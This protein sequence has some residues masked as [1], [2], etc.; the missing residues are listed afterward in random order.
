[1]LVWDEPLI[2]LRVLGGIDKVV[3][4]CFLDPF[5]FLLFS[6]LS[7][8]LRL[9][10]LL[11]LL[12]LLVLR[13]RVVCNLESF[14]NILLNACLLWFMHLFVRWLRKNKLL[15]AFKDDLAFDLRL[16]LR[17]Q[18]RLAIHVAIVVDTVAIGRLL[19]SIEYFEEQGLFLVVN[20]LVPI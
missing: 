2:K 9:G 7:F 3:N 13:L 8:L 12:E 1:M 11:L 16:V 20:N 14:L 5:L 4:P 19:R 17:Q 6:L 10:W 15:L 18:I